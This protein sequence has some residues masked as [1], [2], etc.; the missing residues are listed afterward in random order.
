MDTMNGPRTIMDFFQRPSGLKCPI[1]GDAFPKLADLNRH[2]DLNM[3]QP[4]PTPEEE[5]FDD[6]D[7]D[8]DLHD[9]VV[10]TPPP[11]HHH[12]LSPSPSSSPLK[13]SPT[14]SKFP[15]RFGTSL[16]ALGPIQRT[17]PSSSKARNK[18]HRFSPLSQISSPKKVPRALFLM[19]SPPHVPLTQSKKQDPAHVPYYLVNFECIL[20]G[21]IEETDDRDLLDET[22]LGWIQDF[23]RLEINAKKLYVRLFGRKFGWLTANNIRYEEIANLSQALKDLRDVRFLDSGADLA[24]LESILKLVPAPEIRLLC[25]EFKIVAQ[26]TQKADFIQALLKHSRRKSFFLSSNGNSMEKILRRKASQMVG[27]CFKLVDEVRK[28][29]LRVLSLY[30][31]TN[32]WDERENEKGQP[33]Q[34][35]TLLLMNQGKM[36]FPPYKIIRQRKIFESR[37]DLLAF[38]EACV[39]EARMSEAFDK[40]DWLIAEDIYH[41]AL[42]M[43]K[44]T[45]DQSEYQA[46]AEKL[47][48][49]LRKFTR[50]AILVY[51]LTKSVEVLERNKKHDQAV[52]LI[53]TLLEQDT[54]LPDYRGHWY[55]RLVLD[56]DQHLKQPLESIRQVMNG[57][58]DANVREARKLSLFQ[59]VEKI[60]GAKKNT[61]LL[62]H[63]KT[64]QA[65]SDWLNLAEAPKVEIQGRLMPKDNLPGAKTVFLFEH[66]DQRLLCSVE[67]YVR[68]Y[69][70]TLGFSQG[71]HGEGAVVNTICALLFWD[72]LYDLDIPDAFR[73]PSQPVP[74]DFNT[75]DFYLARKPQIDDRLDDLLHWTDLELNDWVQERWEQS[76]GVISLV[77]WDLFH[78]V[79]HILGLIHCFKRDQL[80]GICDRLIKKHRY[81][82]SGYP[83]LTLWNP[84]TKTV[85]IVEVKGPNDRLSNKQILWL[86]YLNSLGVKAVV[87]HVVAV[88]GKKLSSS[89]FK[90]TRGSPQKAPTPSLSSTSP[91]T[92]GKKRMESHHRSDASRSK[93]RKSN[94]L[95]DSDDDFV[96]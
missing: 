76:H 29:F 4:S 51:V 45:L 85:E 88:G 15:N 24:D 33:Q 6:S 86:D 10:L 84:E 23:Q 36:V 83:D 78:N 19:E 47:P 52:K 18:A 65:R 31:L 90:I 71:L 96:P 49:F 25:K 34:L 81:T 55:E 79:E 69:Y 1:C 39:I 9:L 57:L 77:N 73:S 60:C 74:L 92:I 54:Y 22:E 62:P 26:G 61:K 46:K 20:K 67:E 30:S 72:I 16:E 38:E 3:C 13:A 27:E 44:A 53:Q 80:H 82:R 93:K 43:F 91:Q 40:K 59:R 5:L 11:K 17:S 56:L 68:E 63:L 70:K 41:E 37:S 66:A 8:P 50:G 75:D 64:A 35:T 12:T 7:P 21:V 89:P 87:C 48:V 94:T 14:L 32:W 42:A 95:I 28:V 58:N 2:L